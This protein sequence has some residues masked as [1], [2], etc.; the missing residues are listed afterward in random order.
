MD[1]L[2]VPRGD[3]GVE[4]RIV[5]GEALPYYALGDDGS[6]WSCSPRRGMTIREAWRKVSGWKHPRWGYWIVAIRVN[7]GRRKQFR[8]HRL[9]LETFVGP[10]PPGTEACHRNDNKDDNRLVQLYWGTRS[11][12][13]FD[14]WRNGRRT[15]KIN[16]QTALEIKRCISQGET[17]RQIGDRFGLIPNHVR[18]IR[19]GRAWARVTI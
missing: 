11:E 14:M 12:N 8:L 19:I 4:Y 1:E 6:L 15:A 10:A 18:R 5:R 9:I 16:E 2:T 17:D 13:A 7:G 3:E